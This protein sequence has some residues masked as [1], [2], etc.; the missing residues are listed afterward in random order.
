MPTLRSPKHEIVAQAYASGKTKADSARAAGFSSNSASVDRLF[1][2]EDIQAR[3]AEIVAAK[4]EDEGKARQIGVEKA[5]LTEEWIVTRLMWLTERS[6]RGNPIL[7]RSGEPIPGKFGKPDGQTA[8]RCLEL[9]SR[10]KGL[11][12]NRHEVGDPG[13]FAKMDDQ[14]LDK[15]IA[16]MASELGYS[17]SDIKRAGL[18]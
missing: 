8:A 16:Q 9:A 15:T 13:A 3:I 17:P 7:D 11:L 4:I 14:T 10:I 6:L 2:R 18:H 1:K 12:I 5:G